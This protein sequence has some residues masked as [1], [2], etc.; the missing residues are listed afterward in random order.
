MTAHPKEHTLMSVGVTRKLAS[1][2]GIMFAEMANSRV[3]L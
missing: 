2:M 1:R 3:P